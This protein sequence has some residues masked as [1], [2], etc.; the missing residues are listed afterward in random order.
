MPELN[1][2]E[3]VLMTVRSLANLIATAVHGKTATH[4]VYQAIY[5]GDYVVFNNKSLKCDPAVDIE[6]TNGEPCYIVINDS[7]TMAVIVGK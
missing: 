2:I 1:A 4:A 6:L 3:V 7:G 5:Y